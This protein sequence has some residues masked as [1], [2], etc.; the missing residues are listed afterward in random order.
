MTQSNGARFSGYPHS[1]RFLGTDTRPALC[2]RTDRGG[3]RHEGDINRWLTIRALTLSS[4][5]PWDRGNPRRRGPGRASD[6]SGSDRAAGQRLC[7][8]PTQARRPG[9]E[10]RRLAR[11]APKIR[12]PRPAREHGQRRCLKKRSASTPGATRRRRSTPSSRGRIAT[13]ASSS[14]RRSAP[15]SISTPGNS[16]TS[17]KAFGRPMKASL[18]PK[19]RSAK[20]SPD[21]GALAGHHAYDRLSWP[22]TSTPCPESQP[23]SDSP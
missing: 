5:G 8:P 17:R 7:K 10:P 23:E 3:C 22:L 19:P 18:R 14:T 15:I 11:S 21:G 20:P 9:G 4:G 2:S 13:S 16:S 1:N 6:F 12:V